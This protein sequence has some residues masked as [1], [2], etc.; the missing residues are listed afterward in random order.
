MHKQKKQRNLEIVEFQ[1]RI[2]EKIQRH[3]RMT[4]NIR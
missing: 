4:A 1:A 2:T 3:N